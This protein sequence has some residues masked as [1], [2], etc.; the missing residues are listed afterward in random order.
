MHRGVY[1]MKILPSSFNQNL[2]YGRQNQ[3]TNNNVVMP[4]FNGSISSRDA[5]N[6]IK[7]RFKFI[8]RETSTVM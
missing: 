5:A 8:Y 2:T 4:S 1:I 7:K 3:L 6:F